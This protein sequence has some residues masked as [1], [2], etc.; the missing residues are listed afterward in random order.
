VYA[1]VFFLASRNIDGYPD[2]GLDLALGSDAIPAHLVQSLRIA[3]T[4][5][6]GVVNDA[7]PGV[8]AVIFRRPEVMIGAPE[9]FVPRGAA[10]LILHAHDVCEGLGVSFEPPSDLCYPLREHTRRSPCGRSHGNAGSVV[11]TTRGSTS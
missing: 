6:A 1:P 4:M 8:R 11:P 10:E 9:Y 5:L 3:T 7:G 2:V